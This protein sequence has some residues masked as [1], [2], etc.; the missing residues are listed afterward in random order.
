MTEIEQIR[1]KL[2]K[3]ELRKIQNCSTLKDEQA[4]QLIDCLALYAIIVYDSM[5]R[6]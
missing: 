3:D 4:G 2:T 5:K 6:L 1:L